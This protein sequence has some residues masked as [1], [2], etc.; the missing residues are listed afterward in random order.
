[1]I[2]FSINFYVASS[3]KELLLYYFCATFICAFKKL[4]FCIFFFW[5]SYLVKFIPTQ[6]KSITYQDPINLRTIVYQLFLSFLF[7][8]ASNFYKQVDY[9]G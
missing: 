8:K 6:S 5:I 3:F 4:F 7:M 1:M 2:F 9:L